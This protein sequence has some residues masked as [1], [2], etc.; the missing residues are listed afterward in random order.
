MSEL[1]TMLERL[2]RGYYWYM[3]PAL[4]LAYGGLLMLGK[5]MVHPLDLVLLLTLWLLP[6]W[7]RL[8]LLPVSKKRDPPFAAELGA[9]LERIDAQRTES[10]LPWV[11]ARP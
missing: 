3:R 8:R 2:L 10:K 1:G 7:V 11:R 5:R 6:L 9:A 4:V